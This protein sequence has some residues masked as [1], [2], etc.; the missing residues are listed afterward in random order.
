MTYTFCLIREAAGRGRPQLSAAISRRAFDFLYRWKIME[1]LDWQVYI[2]DRDRPERPW[3]AGFAESLAGTL[4]GEIF[5][6]GSTTC[7]TRMPDWRR[8]KFRCEQQTVHNLASTAG[9]VNYFS[10]PCGSAQ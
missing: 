1:V 4:S 9:L 6:T 2:I 5:T 3:V 10:K 8:P 7:M